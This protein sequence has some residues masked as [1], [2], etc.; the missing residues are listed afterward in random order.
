VTASTLADPYSAVCSAIATLRGPLHGGA[1]SDSIRLILSFSDADA[2]E[3]HIFSSL[4]QKKII[5]GFGHRVYR[6]GDPRSQMIKAW[7]REIATENP[8]RQQAFDVAERIE[9]VML[10]EKGLH[11]NVDYY[12]SL[13]LHFL[14]IPERLFVTIFAMARIIGWSAHIL[15]Q[16]ENNRLI[17]PVSNY[18]GPVR[19]L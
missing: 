16:Q 4:K 19:V 6:M 10:I 7:V 1:L 14:G 3:E 8:S 11:P 15:E 13:L 17:R 9:E 5:P 12:G 2:A 18:V